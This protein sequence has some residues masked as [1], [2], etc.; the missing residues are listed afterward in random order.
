MGKFNESQ[1]RRALYE[2]MEGR[3]FREPVPGCWLWTGSQTEGYGTLW[4][5]RRL[6]YCHLLT[7][8]L[9]I[10]EIPDGLELDH[11]AGIGCVVTRCTSSP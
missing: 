4:L 3:I 5:E 9:F 2:R 10:G 7:Y 8:Q 1:S 6:F 11:V